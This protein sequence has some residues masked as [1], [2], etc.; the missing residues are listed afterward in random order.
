MVHAFPSGPMLLQGFGL[1]IN[2]D[3]S[4]PGAVPAP[5]D[6]RAGG[7]IRITLGDDSHVGEPRPVFRRDG[8]TLHFAPLDLGEYVIS[9]D[10]IHVAK[11][12]GADIGHVAQLLVATALP[13]LLW[14]RGKLVL[15]AAGVVLPGTDRIIALVGD[16][17]AGK[18]TIARYLLDR[19]ARLAGDDTLALAPTDDVISADGL[20]GGLFLGRDSDRT[21]LPIAKSLQAEGRAL[22]AIL[23]L[24]PRREMPVTG[25]LS[26]VEAVQAILSHRHRP[27]IPLLLGMRGQVMQLAGRIAQQV[28]V[29]RWPAPLATEGLLEDSMAGMIAALHGIT[30][31]YG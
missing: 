16:S 30:R 15:H 28:P 5:S 8:D 1:A 18:S 10:A 31:G 3:L 7:A 23:L 27:T 12:P 24:D 25:P 14:M 21:F 4:I 20:A 11:R 13:G 22:G 2:S 17:G 26:G 6:T 9:R 29:L 19:G